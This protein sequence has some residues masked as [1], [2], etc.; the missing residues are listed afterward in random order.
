M[1][2]PDL[3]LPNLVEKK[4]GSSSSG[5]VY[6]APSNLVVDQEAFSYNASPC[7]G[8]FSLSPANFVEENGC[9]SKATSSLEG[10]SLLPTNLIEDETDYTY[11][12]SCSSDRP[13]VLR[14]QK[15]KDKRYTISPIHSNES[16]VDDSDADPHYNLTSEC[17]TDGKEN[18]ETR[19]REDELNQ[20]ENKTKGKKRKANPLDWSFRKT[21]YL[22]NSGKSYTSASKSLKKFGERKMSLPCGEKCRLQCSK[23]IN[24]ET[25]RTIFSNYWQLSDLQRQREYIVAHSDYIKPKYRYSSTENY[26]AMNCAFYFNVNDSR[27]RVCKHF[28]KATLAINDRPIRT[29]LKKKTESGFL[30]SDKRG[31]HGKQPTIDPE[32]KE[33]VRNFI[34][35]IP[36]VE[37]H[38]LRAQ[39]KREYIESGKSLADLHRDYKE[40]R[41]SQGLNFANSV[42]FNRIFNGEFNIGFHSPKKDQCD[43]CESY[44]NSDNEGKLKLQES[45][46]LHLKEKVLSRN[47]KDADKL[48]QDGVH[49]AVYDLQAVM[50]VPKGLVSSF[51]YK[52]KLNCYNFTISDLNL[53]NVDCYFWNESEGKR[54]ANE[55]GSCVL[56]YLKSV[57]DNTDNDTLDVILYSDNCGGQ[58]KNKYLV[59]AYLNAVSTL[60]IRSITHKFLI[61]GHSQN[62]GDNVHS[63]IEK[64]VK[65]HLK[66]NPIYI[67]EQYATLIR[68]AKKVGAP[69]RVHDMTYEDFYDLKSLQEEYGSNFSQ[70]V[71]GEKVKW[72]DL[73]MLRVEKQNPKIFFYK[74]SYEE[75]RFKTVNIVKGKNTRSKDNLQ[76]EVRLVRAYASRISLS[77]NKKRDIKELA[78]KNIIPKIYYNGYFKN[79]ILEN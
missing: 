2:R 40:E 65:R 52:S 76:R 44:K 72:H 42:M 77:E 36:R 54:G 38:Y 26:R 5:Q 4:N 64:Q 41:L 13:M 21:K 45:Y 11:K 73:K 56:H 47:E 22:R 29:A 53:K 9:S 48:N 78:E 59:A 69:Y 57:S 6:F 46:D 30:E 43:L 10:P 28:F 79:I 7:T 49:V 50:P 61:H 14:L 27:L 25:R 68:T 74:N 31:R 37:S 16:D 19:T 60:R 51:Y 15:V 18:P 32:I 8:Q 55:I 66:S 17:D 39:T 23:K 63:V 34:N 1:N 12:A 24:E 33:S 75:A 67:P 20:E 70:N 35:K 71:E 58:Q 62:E 3:P